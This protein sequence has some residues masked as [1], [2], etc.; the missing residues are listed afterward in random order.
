MLVHGGLYGGT[1][2][3]GQLPPA[4]VSRNLN[5]VLWDV[6][7]EELTKAVLRALNSAL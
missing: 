7:G 4:V 3:L 6:A 5:S 1:G 2:P